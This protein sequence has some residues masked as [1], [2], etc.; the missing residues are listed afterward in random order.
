MA[1]SAG[2][3]P[4][5]SSPTTGSAGTPAGPP[6]GVETTG[7]SVLGEEAVVVRARRCREERM[8]SAPAMT[9]TANLPSTMAEAA[10]LTSH[11][12]LFPPMVVTSQA[13]R[14]VPIR[15][16]RSEAGWGPVRVMTLTT[17]TRLTRERRAGTSVNAASQASSMRSPGVVNAVRSMDCPEAMT[18]G[19]RSGSCAV[20]LMG[21]MDACPSRAQATIA[22]L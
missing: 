3:T 22:C 21:G 6:G 15:A 11:C 9:V 14:S 19:M 7:V 17:E 2:P 16:A 4:G 10:R 5:W 13:A 20:V 12:G 18:T 1:D 8:A